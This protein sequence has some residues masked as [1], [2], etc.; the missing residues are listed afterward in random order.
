MQKIRIAVLAVTT[1]LVTVAQVM[2]VSAASV[3]PLQA[4][5]G[6]IIT[7]KWESTN[8]VIPSISISGKQIS[9][10]VLISPK[11][12]SIATTGTL[13]LE[14]KKGGK[15]TEVASWPVDEVGTVAITKT[16]RGIS[17]VTYRTR[18]VVTTG[19]DNIDVASTE[20]TI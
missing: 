1:I 3:A 8:Q 20:R 9:A 19:V 14:K 18:V 13:Y 16:Y 5:S 15:W 6:Q 17:G 11:N 7:P 2:P 12:Q 4:I 10:S